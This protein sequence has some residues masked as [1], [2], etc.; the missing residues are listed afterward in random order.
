MLDRHRL[1]Q[2]SDQ[3][4]QRQRRTDRATRVPRAGGPAVACHGGLELL[5]GLLDRL[6]LDQASDQPYRPHQRQ[7]G[8]AGATRMHRRPEPWHRWSEPLTLK[9]CVAASVLFFAHLS[10]STAHNKVARC[11]EPNHIT[12]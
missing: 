9:T 8:T 2:A 6:H 11:H 12:D 7:R 3:P 4:H 5:P 1:D 10:Y